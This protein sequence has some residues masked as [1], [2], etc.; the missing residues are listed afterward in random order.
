MT[1]VQTC[2]LPILLSE[3]LQKY[4]QN[5]HISEDGGGVIPYFMMFNPQNDQNLIKH[6]NEMY[7]NYNNFVIL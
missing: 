1:G 7:L 6:M 4:S 3:E 2:A 5:I